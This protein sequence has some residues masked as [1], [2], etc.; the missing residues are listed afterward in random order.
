M[1]INPRLQNF[2][3]MDVSLRRPPILEG[4]LARECVICAMNRISPIG[5]VTT[6][7]FISM[8]TVVS[9]FRRTVLLNHHAKMEHECFEAALRSEAEELVGISQT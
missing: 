3:A 8:H 4:I 5:I 1:S 2:A 6:P 7:H 9:P